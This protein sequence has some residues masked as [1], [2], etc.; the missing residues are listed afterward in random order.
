VALLSIVIPAYNEERR[1]GST[2]SGVLAHLKRRRLT[3]EILV[4]DDGSTD[5]TAALVRQRMRREKTLKLVDYS[6]PGNR[7]KGA[8]VKA[9]VEASKGWAVLFSDADLSTPIEELETLL[10]KI[11]AGYDVA[12][13]SR[14]L[15][16]GR[17][18]KRQPFYREAGGRVFNWMVRLL[19]LPDIKDTQCGFKLFRARAAKE[20]FAL[21]RV[22]RFG[23]DVEALYLARKL[24]YRVAECSVAWENSPET[25]VR[26]VA[27]GLRT[28]LDLAL[29]RS[30][31]W[32]G[33]Y[34][35]QN[36]K[37]SGRLG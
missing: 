26:P 19:T 4:V 13:G 31:D 10:L 22:P 35:H 1:L 5:G 8:A 32:R 36:G 14:A 3:H 17:I 12:I 16:R 18:T 23:F 21:Q 15:D 29:I 34:Q 11:K 2:L 33:F 30:Y 28:F 37:L 7:G 27:D 9:G 20:I 24:G 6:S 25:K